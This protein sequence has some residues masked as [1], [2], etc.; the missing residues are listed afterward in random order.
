M[1]RLNQLTTTAGTPSLF[2]KQFAVRSLQF[3]LPTEHCKLITTNFFNL[4]Y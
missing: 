1:L 3:D 4:N 2:S